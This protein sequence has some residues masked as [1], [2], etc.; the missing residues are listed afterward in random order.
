VLLEEDFKKALNWFSLFLP[1]TKGVHIIQPTNPPQA[2]IYIDSCLTGAGALCGDQAY[3]AVYPE[4]IRRQNHHISHLEALNC[5]AAVKQWAP[6]LASKTAVLHCDFATAVAIL[7]VGKGRDTF[8]QQCARELWLVT[9]LH[10]IDLAVEHIA[11]DHLS[12]TADALSRH[13]LGPLYRSRV[14]ELVTTHR[15]TI[16][17]PQAAIFNLSSSL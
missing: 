14:E 3:H 5:M 7:Q 13:H 15:V 1:A 2:E 16:V 17:P 8:I 11:G 12:S 4:A 10:D 6:R 9:A